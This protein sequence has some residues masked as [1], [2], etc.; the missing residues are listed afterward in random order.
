MERLSDE[1]YETKH[2]SG[3]LADSVGGI[4]RRLLREYGPIDPQR[5]PVYQLHGVKLNEH[6]GDTELVVT[7]CHSVGEIDEP[8]EARDRTALPHDE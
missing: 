2:Q 7:G 1:M 3:I 8:A 6:P 4:S 5:G